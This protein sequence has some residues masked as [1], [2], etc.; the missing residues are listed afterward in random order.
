M[1]SIACDPSAIADTDRELW[2]DVAK[3]VYAAVQEVSEL[4]D[5]YA[6]RLPAESALITT[7]AQHVD[8]ERRCCPFVRFSIEVEPEH[9]PMW[10]RVTGGEAAR[11]FFRSVLASADLLSEPLRRGLEHA[12]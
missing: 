5:G 8:F 12:A 1:T 6:F 7:L 4:P 11:A 2:V 9:G 10:L 3:R